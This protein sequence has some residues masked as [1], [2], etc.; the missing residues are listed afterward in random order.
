MNVNDI[1]NQYHPL[2]G[3]CDDDHQHM[4]QIAA[5]ASEGDSY[6]Y[7]KTMHMLQ[8]MAE[9]GG[10]NFVS[11]TVTAGFHGKITD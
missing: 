11:L 1:M 5:A 9:S 3:R 10:S 4:L 8:T 7:H 2:S 6:N